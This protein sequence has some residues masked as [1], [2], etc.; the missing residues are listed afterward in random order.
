M[1]KNKTLE[2]DIKLTTWFMY[3]LEISNNISREG[4]TFP[5]ALYDVTNREHIA[6]LRPLLLVC[7][8]SILISV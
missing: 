7:D 2:N 6:Y 5:A 4:L 1:W 3:S 8:N